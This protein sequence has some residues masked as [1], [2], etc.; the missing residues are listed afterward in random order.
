MSVLVD[1]TIDPTIETVTPTLVIVNVPLASS[2]RPVPPVIVLTL[3]VTLPVD[4]TVPVPATVVNILSPFALS[5]FAL[6]S[7]A[8]TKVAVPVSTK[9]LPVRVNPVKSV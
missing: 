1:V 4:V 3:V 5:P 2:K 7:S 8:T 6:S 9:V